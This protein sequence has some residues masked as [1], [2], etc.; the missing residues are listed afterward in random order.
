MISRIKQLMEQRALTANGFARAA[1]LDPGNFQ[2]KI[3]GQQNIT[4][5]DIYKICTAFGVSR[6]WLVSGEGDMYAPDDTYKTPTI[7]QTND[8]V[9][10]DAQ[11][12]VQSADTA[13]LMAK[14]ELLEKENAWLRSLVEARIKNP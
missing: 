10:G 11:N 5:K 3:K 6:A 12:I 13:A 7:I 4:E 9:H 1:Q 14:V 8:H 2:R